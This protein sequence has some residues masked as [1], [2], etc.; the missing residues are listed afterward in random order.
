MQLFLQMILPRRFIQYESRIEDIR[1]YRRIWRFSVLLTLIVAL[2]PLIITAGVNHFMFRKNLRA[3]MNFDISRNLFNLSRSLEFVVE[4]RL[5]ALRLIVSEKSPSQLQDMENLGM[6]LKNL[7][8]TFG[9]FVDLGLIQ[10]DGIQAAYVGPYNLKGVN[11]SDQ[12][13]FKEAVLRGTYVSDVFL[14]HRQFPHFVILV[15]KEMVNGDFYLLRATVD[16]ELLNRLIFIPNM[17]STDDIFIIN[18]DCILQTESS[19]HGKVLQDLDLPVPPYS[20]FSK[21]TEKIGDVTLPFVLGYSY[22]E[23]TPFIL[24][25][26]KSRVSPFMEWLRRQPELVVFLLISVVLIIAVVFWSST[27]MVKQIRSADQKRTQLLMNVEY[28][29]K[30]ATIGRMA[31]GVAHEINNP[32]AIINE[33]AGLLTDLVSFT[34]DFPQKEKTLNALESIINSVERCSAVTHRLLGFSRKMEIQTQ[35]IDLPSLLDE[36][37]GFLARE[38]EYQNI[39]IFKD[40]D[41]DIPQI[42]SDK[43]Q[44]QQIFLNILNNALAAVSR[45]GKINLMVEKLSK[46]RVNV[47][48]RDNGVGIS[49]ENLQ[50]IFEPFFSTKGDFG[51][52][53]GLSITHS[54]VHKLGGTIDVKSEMEKGTEF[55]ISLPVKNEK[56]QDET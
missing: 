25:V 23:N 45:G 34:E 37:V 48:I 29:N 10:G 54:L 18:H 19:K 14:G 15:K 43:G 42:E 40:Y 17:Q 56:V 52:G 3:E 24:M 2:L 50:H 22:I 30:M 21:V 38:A 8:S 39:R 32:L 41:P 6:T 31:A 4:E 46:D 36:V 13:S 33:K 7:K 5:S 20:P 27:E 9:G 44:L 12:A 55:T 26:T 49:P 35:P 1:R 53:L 16:M 11:Y 28:T 47:I 51:T